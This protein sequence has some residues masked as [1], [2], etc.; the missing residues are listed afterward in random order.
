MTTEETIKDW[1][2]SKGLSAI[3]NPQLSKMGL[4]LTTNKFGQWVAFTRRRAGIPFSRV[5]TVKWVVNLHK[6]TMEFNDSTKEQVW[7]ELFDYE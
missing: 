4:V 7:H 3:E 1:L 2:K 6:L 5:V